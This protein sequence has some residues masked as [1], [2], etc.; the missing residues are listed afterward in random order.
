M[1]KSK[2]MYAT[3][4]ELARI[5][6]VTRPTVYDRVK[7]IEAEIGKRYGK[8]AIIGNLV[9]IGVYADYE[10]YRNILAN[11]HHRKCLAP[12]DLDEAEQ[13]LDKRGVKWA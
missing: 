9:S 11:K 2:Q 7:G 6:G 3:K 12:F 10:K 8:Y 5:F 4:A 13:Y 1:P